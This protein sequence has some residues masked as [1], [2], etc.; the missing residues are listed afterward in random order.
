MDEDFTARLQIYSVEE[1]GTTTAVCIVRC[2][3]GVA[4]TGQHFAYP[5]DVGGSGSRSPMT[6]DWILRYEEPADC[7]EPPHN[8]KVQLS[9]D[10][11]DEL[12][13]G[14]IITA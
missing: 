12:R 10:G 7:L 8:A 6:L 2:V 5:E 3:G 1:K 4:R 13:R 11:I 14:V 9:G